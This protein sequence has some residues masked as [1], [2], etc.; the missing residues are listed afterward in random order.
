MVDLI[1]RI[2]EAAFLPAQWPDVLGAIAEQSNCTSGAL[3][4]VDAHLPPLYAATANTA[5]AL[6][7]FANSPAWYANPRMQCL[8]R[9]DHSGFVNAEEVM[10]PEERARDLVA[11]N[12]RELGLATQLGTGI[13]MPGRELVSFS[14]ERTA[15][16][17]RFRQSDIAWFDRLRPHLARASLMAARAQL[18]QARANVEALNATG[19]AAAVVGA[20]GTVLASN[21]LFETLAPVLRPAAGGRISVRDAEARQLYQEALEATDGAQTVRSIPLRLSDETSAVLQVLP[22]HRSAHDLFGRGT[23]MLVVTGLAVDGN[24]PDDA[25]LR[26]LFDLSASEAA[27]AAGLAKGLTL[28][29][30]AQGRNIGITTARSH[31]AQIFRKTGTGHQHQ[32]VALLKGVT[33]PGSDPGQ[34]ASLP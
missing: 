27:V 34:G 9:I 7:Q 2:Y 12:L 11:G 6:G 17:G 16:Q 30:I 1:D 21:A 26:G 5:D 14:F 10:N 20:S 3:M 19:V 15:E 18:D 31:L 29:Q 22:L 25:I 8:F 13:F 4:I 23:A 33:V 32:L 28:K 24:L